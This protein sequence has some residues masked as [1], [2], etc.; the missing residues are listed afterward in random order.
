MPPY[1]LTATSYPDFWTR[2]SSSF[3]LPAA[4]SPQCTVGKSCLRTVF[5]HRLNNLHRWNFASTIPVTWWWSI[6][7]STRII[8]FMLLPGPAEVRE[9]RR[10][11]ELCPKFSANERKWRTCVGWR[12]STFTCYWHKLCW[13]GP[14]CWKREPR[15]RIKQL[16][17][18]FA[19]RW[20]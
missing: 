18:R 2:V 20:E 8:S 19:W 11:P 14:Q 16:V 10:A 3:P 13:L 6:F 5:W 17:A 4:P 1:E 12:E 15:V 7:I 9:H